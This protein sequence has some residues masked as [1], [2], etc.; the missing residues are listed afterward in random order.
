MYLNTVVPV[1]VVP[2]RL[3]SA[4]RVAGANLQVFDKKISVKL[5]VSKTVRFLSDSERKNI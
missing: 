5:T 3:S 2:W 1:V 4:F